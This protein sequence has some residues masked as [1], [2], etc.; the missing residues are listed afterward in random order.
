TPIDENKGISSFNDEDNG[1]ETYLPQTTTD[2]EDAMFKPGEPEIV[3]IGSNVVTMEVYKNGVVL[4]KMRDKKSKNTFSDDFV[5]GVVKAFERIRENPAYKVVVLTGYD[6]YFASGGTKD[7][8]L[9]I[10]GGKSKFTHTMVYFIAL[11]CDIPVIAAMQGH[12]IGA[13]WSMGMYCDVVVFSERSTYR[14][15][16][17][18]YGFTPGAGSTLIFP[19]QF[20]NDLGREILL[21]AD[22]Y[23]GEE[24]KRRGM[25]NPVRPQGEVQTYAMEIASRLTL[26]SREEL[27]GL[28]AK[29]RERL[30]P[31]VE[32]T[33]DQELTMHEE[34][35]VGNP[36]VLQRLQIHFDNGIQE[37]EKAEVPQSKR[38]AG[39]DSDTD[40]T[41]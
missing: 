19:E 9:A 11:E 1:W 27:T 34:T 35:F 33:I 12:G 32:R 7:A 15:P 16:Y 31:K 3:N 23:K 18:Q 39:G 25:K 28:K 8:L 26:S 36:E 4:I 14:S 24:L 22:E 2:R 20:G 6:T 29:R 10:H 30:K 21:T 38:F 17:M 41:I 37:A 13:G 5:S 40:E